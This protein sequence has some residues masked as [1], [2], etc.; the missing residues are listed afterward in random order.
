MN[1][2][3]GTAH[4]GSEMNM[5]TMAISVEPTVQAKL[6]S[7]VPPC[8]SA[9]CAKRRCTTKSTKAGVIIKDTAK[10]Q[11]RLHKHAG[12]AGTVTALMGVNVRDVSFKG[13]TGGIAAFDLSELEEV[14]A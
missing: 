3:G 11:T 14:T 7:V 9:K 8:L 6:V 5:A 2:K 12:K 1:I 13:R 4:S 10:L